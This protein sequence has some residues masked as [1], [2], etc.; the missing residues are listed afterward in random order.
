MEFWKKN[1][2]KIIA[3]VLIVLVLAAAFVFG[4][5][6]IPEQKDPTEQT[7]I[8]APAEAPAQPT[9]DAETTGESDDT[10]KPPQ[11]AHLRPPTNKQRTKLRQW[12][13]TARSL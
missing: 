11:R 2:W 13:L 10:Q 12:T 3:P 6:N 4:D 9:Q 7:T 8:S 1:K 5:K